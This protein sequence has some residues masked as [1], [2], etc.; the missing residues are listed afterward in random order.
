MGT[1][2]A[3]RCNKTASCKHI[4]VDLEFIDSNVAFDFQVTMS[5][6][7]RSAA[8]SGDV[9]AV[10]LGDG[11]WV[12]A[13]VI[14]DEPGAMN[15]LL[16]AFYDQQASSL[17][18][19]R[20]HVSSLDRYE[21][22][23]IEFVTKELLKSGVWPVIDNTPPAHREQFTELSALRRAGYVGAKIRGAGII[24]MLLMAF[25]GL[26]PWDGLADPEYFDKLL[27]PGARPR[28]PKYQRS[29]SP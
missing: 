1:C 4:S 14:E 24:R 8:T 7:K 2:V 13:Q 6:N 11:T 29:K 20:Q 28:S 21:P 9:F 19:L 17:D 10:S 23:A 16:C 26:Y 18:E 15:S 27:R 25:Y 3:N 22:I 12:L 5:S